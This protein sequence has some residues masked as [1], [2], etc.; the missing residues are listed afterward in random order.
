MKLTAYSG[1]F[2]NDLQKYSKTAVRTVNSCFE[3][4]KKQLFFENSCMFWKKKTAV[5]SVTEYYMNMSYMVD[6]DYGGY[7]DYLTTRF[8]SLV[9]ERLLLNLGTRVESPTSSF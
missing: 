8:C 5:F 9:V 6:N 3:K 4:K 7:R 1:S 2:F